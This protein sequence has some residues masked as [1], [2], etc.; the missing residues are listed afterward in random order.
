MRPFSD[1]EPKGE[2]A[3]VPNANSAT[4]STLGTPSM[5]RAS[6]LASRSPSILTTWPSL[7]CQ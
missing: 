2:M 4:M 6:S 3:L 5:T 7:T 1:G